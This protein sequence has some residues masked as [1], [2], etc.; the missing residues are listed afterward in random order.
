MSE[1][2]VLIKKIRYVLKTEVS[3]SKYLEKLEVDDLILLNDQIQD[4]LFNDQSEQWKRIAKVVKFFPN[5][6]N[7]KVSE[8]V[9]GAQITANICYHID[10][11]DLIG[12][13][14]HLSI[15]FMAEVTEH[16]IPSKSERIVNE[17]P[18]PIIKKVVSYLMKKKQHIVVASFIEVVQRKRLVELVDAISSEDDLVLCA[19]YIRNIELLKDVFS[20]LSRERQVKMMRAALKLGQEMTIRNLFQNMSTS[21]LADLRQFLEKSHPSD[22]NIWK[23]TLE[24]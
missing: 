10:S 5:Y 2:E 1:K 12:V 11:S 3:S 20:G 14:K 15:P 9:I 23:E 8:Q 4:A 18:L 13:S 16:I 6:M 24:H 22:L 17:M 21:Q 19:Q 7:A